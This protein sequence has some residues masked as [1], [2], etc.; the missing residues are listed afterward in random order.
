MGLGVLLR[1]PGMTTVP[2][3][4]DNDVLMEAADFFTDAFWAAK[5]GGSVKELQPRQRSSLL[6]SQIMEFKRRYGPTK[7]GPDRTAELLVTKNRKG[8]VMGCCGIEVDKIP[9]GGFSG[10]ILTQ[11]PLMSNVAVGK[12]FRRRG[13]AEE[14]VSAAET[15]VRKEWGYNEVYLY[16]E[17]RNTPAVRLYQ[18]LGYRKV[19]ADTTATTLMPMEGGGMKQVTTTL[20]CMRKSLSRGPLLGRILPFWN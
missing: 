16:V 1:P 17:Q 6:N 12:Q 18:K 19:W 20:I 5:V 9:D 4:G 10:R 15:L 11:A 2:S 3:L 8:S 13:I 7:Y 14:M